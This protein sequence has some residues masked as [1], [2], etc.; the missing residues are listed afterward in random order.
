[1]AKLCMEEGLISRA[2]PMSNA[3]SFSP[4][5]II[6]ESECDQVIDRFGRALDKLVDQLSSEGIWRQTA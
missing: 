4:P 1:M 3:L 6:S 2:L 5:L